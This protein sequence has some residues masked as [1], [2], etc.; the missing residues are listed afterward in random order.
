M[1]ALD[2]DKIG[3]ENTTKYMEEIRKLGERVKAAFP[4]AGGKGWDDI[5][6]EGKLND[7]YLSDS[8]WR[9]FYL[10]SDTPSC[11]AFFHYCR[12]QKSHHV[13][14]LNRNLYS[15]EIDAKEKSVE[16]NKINYP[17]DGEWNASLA[18]IDNAF[19]AFCRS[20]TSVRAYQSFF[21]LK[22]IFSRMSG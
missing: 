6:R 5:F 18:I 8:V 7:S 9:G 12:T 1:I 15:Y 14:D 16:E 21:I 10:L 4:E 3:N 22:R 20:K 2:N 13:F 19:A 17:V 11:R